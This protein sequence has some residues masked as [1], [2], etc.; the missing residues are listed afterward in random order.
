MAKREEIITI[1][2]VLLPVFIP[3]LDGSVSRSNDSMPSRRASTRSFLIREAATLSDVTVFSM[4]GCLFSE[5]KAGTDLAGSKLTDSEQPASSAE[6]DDGRNNGRTQG[7][8][9][10]ESVGGRPAGV[11][12]NVGRFTRDKVVGRLALSC[13]VGF[14]RPPGASKCRGLKMPSAAP[15]RR[16]RACPAT[17]GATRWGTRGAARPAAL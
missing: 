11:L 7:S 16:R 9:G 14:K 3:V 15:R 10:R 17:R 13:S 8:A 2:E 5:V 12:S 6:M 4:F 1:W